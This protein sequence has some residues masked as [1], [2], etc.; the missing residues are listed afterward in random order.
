TNDCSFATPRSICHP[1]RSNGAFCRCAVEGSWQDLYLFAID[2][3]IAGCPRHGVC[4]WVLGFPC[5][6]VTPDCALGFPL[7]S[8]CEAQP[9]E[10]EGAPSFALLSEGWALP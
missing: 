8:R 5:G 6:T 1:D 10:L 3:A 7:V 2:G 4:A 9:A